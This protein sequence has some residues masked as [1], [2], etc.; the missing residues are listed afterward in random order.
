MSVDFIWDAAKLALNVEPMDGEHRQLIELMNRLQHLY[1]KGAPAV[2]QG[3]AFAALANFTLY[4]F[5]HEE[6]YM[7]GVGYPGLAVH[8]GVHRN[9]MNKLNDHA[10]GFKQSGAFNDGL[11]RFLH[12]WLWAHICGVDTKYAAHAHARKVSN[13]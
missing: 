8:M 3:K 1:L 6:A 10:K 2:D 13:G 4:H 12:M 11:F 9:L 5:E 7:Q